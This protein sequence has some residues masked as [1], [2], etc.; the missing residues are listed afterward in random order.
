MSQRLIR[1]SLSEKA[2]AIMIGYAQLRPGRGFSLRS[3]IMY[4]AQR[5]VTWPIL[6]RLVCRGL[7]ASIRLRH[8]QAGAVLGISAARRVVQ[9][10][11]REG[12]AMMPPF[13]IPGGLA[14]IM[15]YL[16]GENVIGPDGRPVRL[17]DL[18]SGTRMA[19]YPLAAVLACPGLLAAINDPAILGI[20]SEYLGCKPTISSI[21]IR[22]SFPSPASPAETQLFHRDPD[23]WRFLKLFV[24][25]SD[26]DVQSGPHAYVLGSHQTAATLRAKPFR[27]DALVRDY[28]RDNI[29]V[30]TGAAGTTFIADT[31]GIHMGIPPSAGARLIL[32]VQYSLLPI[33]AFQ[34]QPA[35]L[36]D[37]PPVDGYVNRLIVA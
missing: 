36:V 28:G 16:R 5:L 33:F 19:S 18:P 2:R 3:A 24:Y 15:E 32:Q 17:E 1:R 25:L 23:D 7:A 31:H 22:W 26:V 4:Y 27:H 29:L 37:G 30:V 12:L 6:R 35:K 21:G 14:G 34:Y 10:L 9:D 11:G 13:A 8:G 20:A